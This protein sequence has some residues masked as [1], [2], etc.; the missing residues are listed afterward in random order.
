[1]RCSLP[2]NVDAVT[3]RVN[4][5]KGSF[6]RLTYERTVLSFTLQRGST[7]LSGG[8]LTIDSGEAKSS[9]FFVAS[10]LHLRLC[11]FICGRPRFGSGSLKGVRN[12]SVINGSVVGFLRAD[13]GAFF[14]TAHG[15][16]CGVGNGETRYLLRFDGAGKRGGVASLCC[17]A[18]RRY[19]CI[20]AERC[21]NVVS[22][23][24]SRV[25]A[26]VPII[27]SGK[28]GSAVSTCV[29]KVYR[30]R[31]DVCMAALGGKLCKEPLGEPRRSF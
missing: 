13:P 3:E 12:L 7:S 15:G 23:R 27:S 18:T 8:M 30:G 21:L 28:I 4:F 14:L 31:S 9:V 5:V 25:M 10:S 20:N 24:R 11:G 6:L 26:P 17:S 16:L 29:A 22:R 1:M 19:L 2:G